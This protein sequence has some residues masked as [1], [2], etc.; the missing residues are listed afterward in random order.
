M[1]EFKRFFGGPKM[2]TIALS[3][4]DDSSGK[5]TLASFTEPPLAYLLYHSVKMFFA[6]GGSHC[7]V[8]P[9]GIHQATPVL[10]LRGDGGSDPATMYGLEDG[11]NAL[12]QETEPTLIV[13][14]ES[15]KLSPADY[16]TL[17]QAMLLQ[18]NTLGD[19]F[20]I[21]DIYDGAMGLDSASQTTN[22]E[23]YGSNYLKYGA[24]YY[25]FV[26]TRMNFPVNRRETNV[27]LTCNGATSADLSTY[28]N[29]NT[30]LYNFARAALREHFIVL[31]P[32]GPLAGIY[33]RIDSDSGV[34]KAPANV[35]IRKV[36]EP[37]I[38]IDSA[39]QDL[40]NVDAASGKSINAIRSF[41]GKGTLV[42]GARTLAGNDNEWRYISVR[43]FFNMMEESL[44]V[45][46]LWVVFEP[47]DAVLWTNVRT[48][49]IHF[50]HRKWRE[51]ALAGATPDQAFFVHCGLGE[52]MT[53]ADILEGRL[54][55]E[56]GLAPVRPA[57]F[58][59]M[60]V[61]QRMQGT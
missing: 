3:V 7:Y 45:S 15:V 55:I 16:Q 17:V 32:S 19:R 43:R 18:C 41:P 20:S 5:L 48:M 9:V 38:S 14:P 44:K 52:T 2:E 50:L 12:A 39:G 11:L 58:V 25:P 40:L 27:K 51:G 49:I 37:V 8:I 46:T 34:W 42:W 36:L 1:R 47:N 31:P 10:A 13:I 35:K 60:Q 53:P 57:E 30:A 23:Y 24:A 33:A 28:R 26:K 4:N 56:I 6:N 29:S 61:T 21:F 59:I 54:N 22:R